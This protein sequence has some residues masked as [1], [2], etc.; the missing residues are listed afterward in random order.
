LQE[1][2]SERDLSTPFQLFGTDLSATAIAQARK[3]IYA[4]GVVSGVSPER[5][6]RFFLDVHE[7]YQISTSLREHC[8]FAQHNLLRD[9]PFSHLDLLVCQNVLIYLRPDA[10][11]KLMRLFH[12]ALIPHGFLLLGPSD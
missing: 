12:Y 1:Y 8:I 2:L 5:L 11:G 3:G 9:P 7:G 4:P 10:Q 6:G